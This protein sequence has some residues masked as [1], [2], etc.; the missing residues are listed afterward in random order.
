MDNGKPLHVDYFDSTCSLGESIRIV[1]SA[2]VLIDCMLIHQ[3]L[4][5]FTELLQLQLGIKHTTANCSHFMHLNISALLSVQKSIFT[6]KYRPTYPSCTCPS[7]PSSFMYW[8][9]SCTMAYPIPL[10]TS[11]VVIIYN[12]ILVQQ[13]KMM[14]TLQAVNYMCT[15]LYIKILP[16]QPDDYQQ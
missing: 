7:L 5:F 9:L 16:I 1:V 15:I 3:K 11:N 6:H 12:L 13:H 8:S 2:L 10:N 14:I 4:I